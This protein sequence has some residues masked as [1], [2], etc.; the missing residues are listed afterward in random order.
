[1][2]SKE[3]LRKEGKNEVGRNRR[4]E[5]EEE[6]MGWDRKRKEKMGLDQKGPNR[7]RTRRTRTRRTMMGTPMRTTIQLTNLLKK[8]PKVSICIKPAIKTCSVL[9]I[10]FE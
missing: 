7:M 8:D 10:F 9:L 6:E 2:I 4:T 5:E 1:M 3:L